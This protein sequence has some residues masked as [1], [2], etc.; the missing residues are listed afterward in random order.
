MNS[1]S[2]LQLQE[3]KKSILKIENP[4]CM[5]D[6]SKFW[7]AQTTICLLIEQTD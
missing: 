3:R 7:E 6:L 2:N 5:H 1:K 4:S